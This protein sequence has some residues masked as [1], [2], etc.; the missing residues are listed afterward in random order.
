MPAAKCSRRNN[1]PGIKRA[2]S[3]NKILLVRNQTL[4]R[5]SIAVKRFII[6]KKYAT[7][8][9]KFSWYVRKSLTV[10]STGYLIIKKMSVT[11][12]MVQIMRRKKRPS[13]CICCVLRI[14]LAMFLHYHPLASSA[15]RAAV[16]SASC[17]DLPSPC[18]NNISF[19]YTPTVKCL[20]WSGPVSLSTV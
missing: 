16:C 2:T 6:K 17:L 1:T 7:F 20:S 10:R 4:K 15:A 9:N 8:P 18:A 12:N 5:I 13:F 19:A 11:R 3:T 14:G